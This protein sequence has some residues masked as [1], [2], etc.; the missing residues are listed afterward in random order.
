MR[1]ARQL[2]PWG[3][4]L[5][6]KDGGITS[7]RDRVSDVGCTE[8]CDPGNEVESV[9]DEDKGCENESWCLVGF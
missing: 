3:A 8:G 5:Q 2:G 4:S 7:L 6:R 9:V 1:A